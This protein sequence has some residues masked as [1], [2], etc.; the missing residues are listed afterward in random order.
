[1]RLLVIY[2]ISDDG[3][4]GH[5][6]ELLKDFGLRRVQYSAYA[7]DLTRNRREM[8]EIRVSGLLARDERSRPTDRVYVLPMCDACF[9]GARFLGEQAEFPDKRRDRF[10][11][12]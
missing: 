8:M 6:C 12:L 10:E 11:V 7:G 5:A 9:G 2:D 3:L 4:R 1:M